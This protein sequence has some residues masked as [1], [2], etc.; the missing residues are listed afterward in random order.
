[1]AV[2]KY[3]KIISMTV[4]FLLLYIYFLGGAGNSRQPQ[5]SDLRA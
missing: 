5:E 4:L 3:I 2:A 1:M